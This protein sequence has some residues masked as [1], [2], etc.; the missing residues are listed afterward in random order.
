[1]NE[2]YITK[3]ELEK[4]LEVIKENQVEGAVKLMYDSSSGIGSTIDMEFD[5]IL[6]NRPVVIRTNI[7]D[8]DN[9]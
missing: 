5:H 9:W 7:T 3:E 4:V 6:N 1:M 8:V 2:I